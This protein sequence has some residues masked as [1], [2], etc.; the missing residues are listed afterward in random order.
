MF[1]FCHSLTLTVFNFT[2]INE[3]LQRLE[4]IALSAPPVWAEEGNH[5]NLGTYPAGSTISLYINARDPDGGSV[6]YSKIFGSLPDGV[7][8]DTNS[9]RLY[10]LA[11][12]IDAS[13][14]FGIRVLDQ[15]GKYAD[16]AFSLDIRGPALSNNTDLEQSTMADDGPTVWSHG[17]SDDSYCMNEGNCSAISDGPYS[18]MNCDCPSAY[19]GDRCAIYCVDNPIGLSD[20]SKFNDSQFTGQS[21]YSN[22]QYYPWYGQSTYSNYQYYPW[23]GR[24]HNNNAWRGTGRG[25][26]L[27]ISFQ[28]LY[29]VFAVAT[30]GDGLY[31]SYGV[32]H[33]KLYFSSDGDQF[34]VYT[35]YF[36][37]KTFINTGG[38][39]VKKNTLAFPPIMRAIRFYVVSNVIRATLRVEVYGCK[40]NE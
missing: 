22:Y 21:T 20:R 35:E 40:V 16:A 27:Q 1:L 31:S 14:S 13:F 6:T 39:V 29:K 8:L 25:A 32:R 10:G 9:G 24:L 33:F 30:Q 34:T 19:G 23:Y 17:C 37:E 15:H 26:Y 7:T 11:T 12:S 3:R 2:L 38:N 36:V 28:D 5:G 4:D 18:S